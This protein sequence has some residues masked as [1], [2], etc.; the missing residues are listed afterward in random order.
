MLTQNEANLGY[1]TD[2]RHRYECLM[3]LAEG[4]DA[5]CGMVLYHD[6][7][8]SPDNPSGRCAYLMNIYVR[9]GFRRHAPGR[10]QCGVSE[11]RRQSLR[12]LLPSVKICSQ[13]II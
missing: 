4:K 8:P 9:S 2:C 12:A 10:H 3:A 11:E 5:G 6:E 13:C 1:L 7:L